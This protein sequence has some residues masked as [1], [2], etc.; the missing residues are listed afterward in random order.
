M[1]ETVKSDGA[2]GETREFLLLA[3]LGARVRKIAAEV[4]GESPTDGSP[5]PL[6]RLR[7]VL[8][9]EADDASIEREAGEILAR[10]EDDT[11]WHEFIHRLGERDFE[12]RATDE[13]LSALNAGGPY[14]ERVAWHYD[15]WKRETGE[16]G[17]ERIEIVDDDEFRS[18][19]EV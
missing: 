7:T 10:Y 12:R 19:E 13:E 16:H 9:V 14:P 15:V 11:F 17:I 6:V 2:T 5:D 1:V 3:L 4:A 8:G 18:R